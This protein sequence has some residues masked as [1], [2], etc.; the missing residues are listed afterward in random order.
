MQVF[1]RRYHKAAF[2]EVREDEGAATLSEGGNEQ[3]SEEPPGRRIPGTPS[4]E[5]ASSQAGISKGTGSI[6]A[7][8]KAAATEGARSSGSETVGAEGSAGTEG[9][10]STR[11]AA[12]HSGKGQAH[13][14]S[15]RAAVVCD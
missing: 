10:G 7:R 2:A 9:Q 5:R 13:Q 8:L 4:E 12:A 6:D 1:S 14:R 15:K 3:L 11:Q